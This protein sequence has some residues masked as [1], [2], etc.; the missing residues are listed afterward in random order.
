MKNMLTNH[1]ATFYGL[2]QVCVCVSEWQGEENIINNPN[3]SEPIICHM[4]NGGWICGKENM[5]LQSI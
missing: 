3:S 5:I 4:I 2:M 1:L